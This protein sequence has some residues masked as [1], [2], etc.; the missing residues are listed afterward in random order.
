M[1]VFISFPI[2]LY[3]IPCTNLRSIA[4][5]SAL[6]TIPPPE[7]NISRAGEI[8]KSKMEVITDK[9]KRLHNEVSDSPRKERWVKPE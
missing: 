8:S 3:D 5:A 9:K 6:T 7:T 1:S 4:R 2:N